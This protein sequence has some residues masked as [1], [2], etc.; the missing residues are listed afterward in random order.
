MGV[1][2]YIWSIEVRGSKV[3]TEKIKLKAKLQ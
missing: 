3:A 1:Y 2:I